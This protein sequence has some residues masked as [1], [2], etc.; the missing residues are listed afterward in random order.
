MALDPDFSQRCSGNRSGMS[1]LGK[2]QPKVV[3]RGLDPRIH[4]V[5]GAVGGRCEDVD[6]RTKSGYD[7]FELRKRP[8]PEFSHWL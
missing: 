3:M 7:D 6:G 1:C 2:S 8:S 4:A 5:A